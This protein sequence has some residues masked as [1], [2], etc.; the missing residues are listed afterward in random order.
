L[1]EQ[2]YNTIPP[3]HHVCYNK[4]NNFA[5]DGPFYFA[6][7]ELKRSTAVDTFQVF[8]IQNPT[9]IDENTTVPDDSNEAQF[10]AIIMLVV[11]TLITP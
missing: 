8:D 1:C 6:T 7:S 5:S 2:W 10:L 11:T 3:Y 9:K 4:V